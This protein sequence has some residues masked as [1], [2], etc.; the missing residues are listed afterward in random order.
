MANSAT[1]VAFTP[2][3]TRV[4]TMLR[5]ALRAEALDLD[6]VQVAEAWTH[7]ATIVLAEL[8]A[9][10]SRIGLGTGVISVWG[11]TPASIAL[12]A[13]GLQ[14]ASG[15]RFS[16]GLGA[17]SPPLT[18]G[19]H[20]L[21]WERPVARVRETLIAVRALLAG[22]RLPR[23]AAG[24]RPLR[25]G[26]VPEVPVPI[27]LAALA[28]SSIR[29]A[30]ELADEWAPFLWARSRLAEGRALLDEGEARADLPRATRI[31]AAVPVALGP[32][33]ESARR[34][35]AWWLS[36]YT[37]RM[38]PIY[39]RLLERFSNRQ[40]VEAMRAEPQDLPDAAE[41]LAREVTLFGTYD[42]GPEQI[43]AWLAAGADSVQLVLP[44]GR[45]EAELAEIVEVAAAL[46]PTT[47]V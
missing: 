43:A 25:L 3:E 31:T 4:D 18:E 30:G 2:F 39:P 42:E 15:G 10:T 29:L 33:A 23:P 22:E 44:P 41:P 1:G 45:P 47:N 37:T 19:L 35:A 6:R 7:D 36:T 34:L 8:A 20:G 46:Q 9:Q 28:D 13:A 5:L 14:R 26:V 38:G 17:G 11:R 16:L 21:R 40:T 24:A 12:A 27:A 32:D